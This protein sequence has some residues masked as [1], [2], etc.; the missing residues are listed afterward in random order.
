MAKKLTKKQI[1]QYEHDKAERTNIPHVGLVTPASDPDT[2]AKKKYEY[3]PHLDPQLQWA[4]KTEHTSFEVP[5][6]SLHVHERIDPKTIIESVKKEHDDGGQMSM[7]S[8]KKPL[9]EAIDFYK[10]KEG[11]TNRLIAGDSLLVMNSLLEKEGMAGKVQMM[12]FDPPYGIKYGSNFMPFINQKDVRDGKDGDL[13]SEP[14]MIKA[15]RDTWEL[16][17]HSYLTYL[18]DRLKLA[19]EILSESGSIFLQISEENVHLVRTLLDEIFGINNFCSQIIFRTKLMPFGSKT[20]E[21]ICDYILWYTKDKTKLSVN[22]L[23]KVDNPKGNS[24]WNYIELEDN[25]IKKLT[26]EEIENHELLPKSSKLFTIQPMRPA[27]YRPNQ[28]FKIEFMGEMYRPNQGQCWSTHKE[29]F[30]SLID[31]NRIIKSGNTLGYK[32]YFNDYP[33]TKLNSSWLDTGPAF[34]KTYV[35]QTS[36]EVI[37]RCMMLCTHPG[38]LVLDITCGSGTTAL[39]SEDYGRRW[40]TCDTSRISL[41]IAKKRLMTAQFNYYKLAYPNEGVGSGFIYKKAP[42]ITLGSIANNLPEAFETLQDQPKLDNSKSRITGP[43]TVEAVPAPYA[44]SFDE[45][46]QED[47][48]SD[49]SIARSGETNRQAEWR[50]ELLRTGVRAKGGNIIQFT[51]VEPLAGTKYI[52]AEAETKEDIPKKVLVVFGPE[53]APLEQRMVEN[54]WQEARALKPDMLLFCAFQFDEEAAKDIDELTP[55]IAGMQLIKA[56]MNADMLTDDLRKKRS[57]NES[58]WLVGQP[59]V[60]IHKLDDGK[61]QVEVMGF[62]YYNPKTGTVESGGKKNIAMW[63]LDTDYDNRSLFPSQV[64]FPMAG[65]KDGWAKL[66]KNLK[67]EIDEQ[68]IEA[69]KGTISLPFEA[70]SAVAVKI[71]DDR[72]IESLRVI[73]I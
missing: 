46:E 7:F 21:P 4:G 6:V 48:G 62:D 10:H 23:F 17:I 1:E 14:E 19:K 65:A 30:Q 64:F 72:G 25:S 13:N 39:V 27:Q 68:K 9:R 18:R 53:H 29:G 71:I 42:H 43:F 44:K 59:D 51:R 37:K 20:L 15:F 66:A 32:L 56:Q 3:D 28:D 35:V 57:S 31:N 36:P 69:F 8:E 11:W 50:D 2:G 38:D 33:L 34:G 63:M 49:T 45:L 47:T 60:R 61:T 73:T 16:G 24:R 26:K 67:A 22:H 12:F 70:G 40:I 58:F 5:T 54:A 41:T 55:A 52:Q